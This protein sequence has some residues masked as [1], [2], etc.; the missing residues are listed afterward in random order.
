M[1]TLILI[2][3]TLSLLISSYVLWRIMPRVKKRAGTSVLLDTS[4]LMD[5]RII[6]VVKSGFVPAE[7][8]IPRFV[9]AELQLL[10]DKADHLKRE[11]ARFGQC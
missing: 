4:A 7:L 11:R 2:I 9:I 10:A 1:L 5:G 6:E 3:S 8:L